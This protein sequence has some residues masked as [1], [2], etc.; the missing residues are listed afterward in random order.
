MAADDINE[1]TITGNLVKDPELRATRKGTQVL[2]FRIASNR[3]YKNQ[4]T[5]EWEQV[6]DYVTCAVM[7]ARAEALSRILSKGA[8]V[9]V[10]GSLRYREWDGEDGQH[11]SMHEI[12]VL[13]VVLMSKRASQG[14]GEPAQDAG[15]Q[16]P[17]TYDYDLPF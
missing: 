15:D 9:A 7:G 4:Q 16:G 6:A 2:T 11:H 1:I 14:D 17:D 12:H 8:K 3:S 5:G 13:N 10:N